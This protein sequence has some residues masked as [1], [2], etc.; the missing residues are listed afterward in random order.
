LYRVNHLETG[1]LQ[2]KLLSMIMERADRERRMEIR[3]LLLEKIL[4]LSQ[5]IAVGS[6]GV[7]KSRVT[8]YRPGLDE[9]DVDRTLEEQ[10]GRRQFDCE[11][12][13]CHE[14]IKQPGSYVLMLDVSN[15]M[16]QEKVAVGAIATG[17]FARKLRNDFHGVMT[18]SRS[19]T[20]IKHALEPNNLEQLT[21]R[22]LDIQSG[23]ATNIRQALLEGWSLLNRAQTMTKT[24][25]I[26]T[27][28]W[29]TVGGDP[30]EAAAKYDRLHVLGISFG[31]GGFDTS[32]NAAM[33]KRGRGRYLHVRNFDD[34][35]MAISRI[36]TNR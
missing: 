16:H 36:L 2:V 31:L 23:G 9:L 14:R 13:Y 24:G 1:F 20:V 12:I 15:S 8:P 7:R 5:K 28:G 29:A 27:D 10:I 35:P 22:M 21:N 6:S 33:A 34:L 17:V 19:T 32:T 4:F 30:V 18:F 26:V 3:K 25:I 11:N